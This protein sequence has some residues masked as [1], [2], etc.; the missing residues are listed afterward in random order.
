[1]PSEP[2]KVEAGPAPSQKPGADKGGALSCLGATLVFALL[3]S[4]WW[5]L[6]HSFPL[7]D[8][9]SH[10]Q[11]AIKYAQLLRHPHLLQGSFWQEFLTVSFNYPLT[12]HLIF[13]ASKALFGYGRF[14]DALVNVLYLLLLSGSL[15]RLTRLSGG[16]WTAA[17]L[18]IVLVNCYPTVAQYSHSQMLDFGHITLSCLGLCSLAQWWQKKNAANTLLMCIALSLAVTAKQAALV[19]LL[20]PGLLVLL[21]TIAAKD[22]KALCQLLAAALCASLS[23]LLWLIPNRESLSAWRDYYTP[24]A[25][26]HAGP[27]LVFF[28]HLWLYLTSLPHL[29]SPL[30]FLIWLISLGSVHKV[31]S[32]VPRMLL[33]S[34]MV[35]GIPLMCV[36]SMNNAEARYIMPALLSPALESALLL[37]S[38]WQ[39]GCYGKPLKLA[40]ALTF[41]LSLGQYF[42][43]NFCPYPINLPEKMVKLARGLTLCETDL[44]GP[45]FAPVP[46]GDPWGQEWL[47]E[48]IRTYE[49]GGKCTLNMLPSTKELSVHTLTVAFLLAN[50]P[51]NIST[52]RRF[53]LNGDVFTCSPGDIDYFDWYLVKDGFNGKNLADAAS[54]K[55]YKDLETLLATNP[56]FK[57][58]AQKTLPDQSTV[59]LYRRIKRP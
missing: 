28:E 41:L 22:K 32:S 4:G 47:I 56:S 16:S 27:F 15:A 20:V 11:D 59:K 58:I 50:Y 54:E 53:T 31:R 12:Q 6:D 35:T 18:A 3:L 17:L 14:S 10:F 39:A 44:V 29:M 2:Q 24:Q 45:S 5:Y 8:A 9:G 25:T 13:G 48:Q 46:P 51:I 38:W 19:F 23:L 43:L 55:A 40:S 49:K 26:Q 30:L 1:M 52:F 42:L 37:A 7:W 34:G 36:L 21:K 33:L 57:F